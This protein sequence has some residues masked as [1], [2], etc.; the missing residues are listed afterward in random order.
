MCFFPLVW[1]KTWYGSKTDLK[2][3]QSMKTHWFCMWCLLRISVNANEVLCLMVS[4]R[5]TLCLCVS[6]FSWCLR[7]WCP[8]NGVC[9]PSEE[10]RVRAISAVVF[11]RREHACERLHYLLP[12]HKPTRRRASFESRLKKQSP[13]TAIPQSSMLSCELRW[14]QTLI[15]RQNMF[16]TKL[17]ERVCVCVLIC[18]N[19]SHFDC[20][21][22]AYFYFASSFLF[23]WCHWGGCVG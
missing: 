22:T 1:Q 4:L 14:L 7:R 8:V 21:V 9:W 3:D 11:M 20:L 2:T 23:S 15:T 5:L 10:S 18:L 16:Y 12:P 13:N 19:M 17:K 6:G